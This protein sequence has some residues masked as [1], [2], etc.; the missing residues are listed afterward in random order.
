MFPLGL[1]DHSNIDALK[2]CEIVVHWQIPILANRLPSLL[3]GTCEENILSNQV[4]HFFGVVSL[5]H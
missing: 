4:L 1:L 3:F 5:V 2:S